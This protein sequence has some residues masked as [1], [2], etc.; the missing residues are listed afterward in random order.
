MLKH[1]RV[2]NVHFDHH[3]KVFVLALL[4]FAALC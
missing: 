3:R 4:V 1:L 2:A